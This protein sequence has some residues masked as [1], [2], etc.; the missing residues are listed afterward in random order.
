MNGKWVCNRYAATMLMV[1]LVLAA[2]AGAGPGT[3]HAAPAPLTAE[4]V[5][6]AEVTL[7]PPPIRLG[8]LGQI[9]KDQLGVHLACRH[10]VAGEYVR[11]GPGKHTVRDVL[12]AITASAALTAE[13]LTD[14]DRVIV[15]L[16]QVPDAQILAEM[17]ELARSDDVLKRA[18]AA[19]WLEFVGG[20]DALVQLLKMLADPAV[21]V[22]HFAARSI[23]TGWPS[24]GGWLATSSMVSGVAPEG[25]G[26]ALA[27]TLE[28]EPAAGPGTWRETRRNMLWIASRLRDPKML[29]VLKKLLTETGKKTKKPG[30]VGYPAYVICDAIVAI[31][32]PAAEKILLDAFDKASGFAAT[33]IQQSLLDM[34]NKAAFARLRKQ[35]NAEMK[36]G[37]RAQLYRVIGMLGSSGNPAAVRDL[38]RILDHPSLRPSERITAT[39][40]LAGFDTPEARAAC[41]AKIKATPDPAA[42]RSLAEAMLGGAH[43]GKL[44]DVRKELFADM[45][46]GGSARRNAALALAR[47]Y[48]PRLAPAL[49]EIVGAD[50][51]TLKADG[52][53]SRAV[54]W[55]AIHAL[56]R[57]GSPEGEKALIA[58]LKDR[59]VLRG[60]V[61][62]ALGNIAS[63]RARATLRATLQ[64][65]DGYMRSC[66]AEALAER[67]D[68][69]DLDALLAA[70][71]LVRTRR[72]KAFDPSSK[73]IWTAVAAIG[74]KRAAAELLAA[75]RENSMAARALVASRNQHCVNAVRDAFLGDD[76]KLRGLLLASFPTYSDPRLSAYYAV[77]VLVAELP[78]TDAKLKPLRATLLGWTHDPRG[79]D[80]L[81]R[82]LIDAKEALVVRQAAL[83]GLYATAGSRRTAD[84]GAVESMRH[85]MEHDASQA[86]KARAKAALTSWGVIPIERPGIPRPKDPPFPKDP[87]DE[88]EFPPPPDP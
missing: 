24:S 38:I 83:K 86:V 9:L 80:A 87:G 34:N 29:P 59:G 63:P 81:G 22:R 41:L 37:K 69:A 73:A 61:L 20:R 46:K 26:L 47:T 57:M 14:R 52:A 23:V 12:A 58:M 78:G 27:R 39:R 11:P 15:C 30:A 48:D 72:E 76:A 51:A 10:Q 31:G 70:A 1:V 32:G 45:A 50:D 6:D 25:T 5:L 13:I 82:I 49:V 79:T 54:R 3:L 55:K 43:G 88:R 36:K 42:R 75:A 2:T 19:H 40:Y 77:D 67:P 71:G 74:G 17:L 4:T 8:K 65:P 21:R 16:W 56:G 60:T 44:V 68:P 66:A 33:R 35:V 62:T 84:P 18:T 85:A 28:T 64:G 53:D 7:P